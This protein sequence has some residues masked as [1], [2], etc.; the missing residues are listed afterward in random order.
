MEQCA[1]RR[2]VGRRAPGC[3]LSPRQNERRNPEGRSTL[4]RFIRPGAS[5][6]GSRPSHWTL[7]VSPGSQLRSAPIWGLFPPRSTDLTWYDVIWA[8]IIPHPN[9]ADSIRAR[10][11]SSHPTQARST[12][13][14]RLGGARPSS[15]ERLAPKPTVSP[16]YGLLNLTARYE[17]TTT[18][19]KTIR[20]MAT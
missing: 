10:I 7:R 13:P 9:R 5:W 3:I 8:S 4:E 1:V 14:F 19:D 20:V 18:A 12:I 6:F 2:K 16:V 11:Q 15:R 17:T